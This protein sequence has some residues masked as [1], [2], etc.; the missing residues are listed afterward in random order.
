MIGLD[1][2]CLLRYFVHDDAKQYP[3]I[4]ARINRETQAGQS[5]YVSHV[6]LCEFVWVIAQGYGFSKSDVLAVLHAMLS[7]SQF[8]FEQRALVMHV[9]G[10]YTASGAGFT[11]C[12][13]ARK[14]NAAG[15]K[16]TLTF[17][18]KM[19]GLVGCEVL[20]S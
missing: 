12:L 20:Q 11:D 3:I 2:N 1:S 8:E 9:V 16:A 17:D 15:C 18:K 4:S 14:N 5:F 19:K 7:S 6:V 10:D 13:I